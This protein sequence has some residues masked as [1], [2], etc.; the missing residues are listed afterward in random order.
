MRAV[1][2]IVWLPVIALASVVTYATGDLWAFPITA[3]WPAIIAW[4]ITAKFRAISESERHRLACLETVDP[5]DFEAANLTTPPAE[6]AFP[7]Q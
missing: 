7:R 1:L 3:F 2:L 6:Q 4:R 5:P